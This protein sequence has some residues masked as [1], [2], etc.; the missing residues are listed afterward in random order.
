METQI[1]LI[2]SRLPE[3]I[4]EPI[5]VHITINDFQFEPKTR[6]YDGLYGFTTSKKIA[7]AFMKI[8]YARYFRMVKRKITPEEYKKM[9]NDPTIDERIIQERLLTCGRG[10]EVAVA[11]TNGEF[12]AISD[13]FSSKVSEMAELSY[14]DPETFPPY[15]L[16][17]RKYQEALDIAYYATI[18]MVYLFTPFH[19]S[20]NTDYDDDAGVNTEVE[21]AADGMN[22]GLSYPSGK[23][24]YLQNNELAIYCKCFAEILN[25]A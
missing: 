18:F 23:T 7:K 4:F 12:D 8:H 20:W 17:K 6:L 9:V 25:M 11:L 2:Y 13:Y 10:K 5:S 16:F 21:I 1:Y 15:Q 19:A 24:L 14:D 3:Q 22:Y